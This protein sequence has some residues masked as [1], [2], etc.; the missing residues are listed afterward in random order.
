MVTNVINYAI[1]NGNLENMK[2]LKETGCSWGLYSN[3]P[4]NDNL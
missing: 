4:L 3:L 1:E 2:W